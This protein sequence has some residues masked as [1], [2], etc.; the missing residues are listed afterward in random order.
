MIIGI[1]AITNLRLLVVIKLIIV[2]IQNLAIMLKISLDISV[3]D[4]CKLLQVDVL[5]LC[6]LL[7]KY[8][9]P[10]FTSIRK[11]YPGRIPSTI[12][13]HAIV[14]VSLTFALLIFLILLSYLILTCIYPFIDS[15][16]ALFL[17]FFHQIHQSY[18]IIHLQSNL[19]MLYQ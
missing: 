6:Y 5:K 7:D 16:N 4:D 14:S 9:F 13:I 8:P 1:T 18:T 11:I 19:I 10:S 15:L 2:V 12:L 17:L 3:H